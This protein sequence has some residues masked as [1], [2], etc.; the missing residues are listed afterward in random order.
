L[1]GFPHR[2]IKSVFHLRGE[3][4]MI[5]DHFTGM[6]KN[7]YN[8]L[9]LTVLT[10]MC[11][12]TFAGCAYRSRPL[13]PID[14]KVYPSGS[15]YIYQPLNP[16]TVWIRDPSEDEKKE[17]YLDADETSYEFNK[18]LLRDLDTETVRV[19]LNTLSGNVNVGA[20]IVGTS[21]KGQNYV[22]IVDYI[23]YITNS[24]RVITKY[25]SVDAE[26]Q[27]IEKPFE[28]TVPM[29][30]GIGLRIRAEF[31]A[32]EGGLNISGLPAIAIAASSNY[33]SG[34]L[35]VQTL[36]ITGPEVTGLM[37][38]ISDISVASIQSALQAVAAIKTKIYDQSTA[39]S[40]KIVGFESPGRDPELIRAITEVFYASHEWICPTVIKNPQDNSKTILWIDW[41]SPPPEEGN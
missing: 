13:D 14:S 22:L 11:I 35:T 1:G 31:T 40:P 8:T 24:K 5:T 2:K 10:C 15:A 32:L 26:G 23:K 37:P 27:D 36:G 25:L 33:I 30:T 38:L 21:V 41:F 39:V 20:G 4:I 12:M 18:A 19:A 34:R 3:V 16:T 9:F 28:G 6:N 17:G 7:L 29:Y